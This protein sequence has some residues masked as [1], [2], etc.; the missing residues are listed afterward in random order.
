MKRS[1]DPDD[2]AE[3]SSPSTGSED[4]DSA[5]SRSKIVEIDPGDEAAN[6]ACLLHKEKMTFASYSEYESH[7]NKEHVNRCFDCR[8][9]FPSSHLLGVHIEDCHDPLVAVKPEKG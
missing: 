2:E 8:K 3:P 7:Y 6:M 5:A 1:R 9:N 4:L